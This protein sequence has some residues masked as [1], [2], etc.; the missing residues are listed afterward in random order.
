MKRA[1]KPWSGKVHDSVIG[2]A[3]KIHDSFER[4]GFSHIDVAKITVEL[5]EDI[6]IRTF[7]EMDTRWAIVYGIKFRM[8]PK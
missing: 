4:E 6:W 7:F 5:P 3:R 1:L 8:V 2:V